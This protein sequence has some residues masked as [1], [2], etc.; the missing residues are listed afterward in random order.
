[1]FVVFHRMPA[2][3]DFDALRA[4]GIFGGTIFNNLPMVMVNAT[5]SQIAAISTLRSVRT[6]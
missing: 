6:I 3:A 5:R 2:P 4:A 1:M